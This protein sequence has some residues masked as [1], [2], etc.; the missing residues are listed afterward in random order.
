MAQFFLKIDFLVQHMGT[1]PQVKMASRYGLHPSDYGSCLSILI[2]YDLSNR[3]D[4]EAVF[5]DRLSLSNR[6]DREAVFPD[7]LSL[8]NRTDREAVFP[9]RLSLSNRTDREAVFPDRLSL[10]NR[11]D[12]EAVFSDRISLSILDMTDRKLLLIC[13]IQ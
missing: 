3:T 4:R 6:T 9:D 7:R 8:S 11:T 5:P 13:F 1:S 10:S 12:R 2:I